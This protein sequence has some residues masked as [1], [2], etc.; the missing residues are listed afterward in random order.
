VAAVPIASQSRLKKKKTD[1]KSAVAVML[2]TFIREGTIQIF[3]KVSSPDLCISW[4][5][6]VAPGIPGQCLEIGY[7][8]FLPHP[9][10]ILR[11]LIFHI[12]GST[13]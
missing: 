8:P 12:L 7:E 3:A 4:F 9:F 2:L 1:Q 5:Y 6:S 10:Q 13:V 11:S